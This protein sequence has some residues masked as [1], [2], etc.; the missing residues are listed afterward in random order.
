[1]ERMSLI[2]KFLELFGHLIPRYSNFVNVNYLTFLRSLFQLAYSTLIHFL[3]LRRLFFI[4]FRRRFMLLR[5]QVPDSA[6]NLTAQG[7]EG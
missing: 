5:M 4:G 2:Y 3:M 7:S 1:M 6:D